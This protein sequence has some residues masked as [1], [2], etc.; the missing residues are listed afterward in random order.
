MIYPIEPPVEVDE[1][2]I[3]KEDNDTADRLRDLWDT[4]TDIL[5]G[6]TIF[7]TA[8]SEDDSDEDDEEDD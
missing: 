8:S 3:I 6:I 1:Q 4:G 7:A 5:D 2:A